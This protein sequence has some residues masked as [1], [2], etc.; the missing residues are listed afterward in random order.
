MD[1]ALPTTMGGGGKLGLQQGWSGTKTWVALESR[2]AVEWEL[3]QVLLDAV[4]L[5]LRLIWEEESLLWWV[6]QYPCTA[7]LGDPAEEVQEGSPWARHLWA[8]YYGWRIWE[9][10]ETREMAV[11]SALN[12][13]P[14]K[15]E[16]NHMKQS[17]KKKK[18]RKHVK[19]IH[20]PFVGM[21]SF[22]WKL[23]LMCRWIC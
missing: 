17:K 19:R 3:F 21:W 7:E 5:F 12:Q 10:G 13:L 1:K 4:L 23:G 14:F 22:G 11:W 15:A 8:H 18:I 20:V 9:G 6:D 2:S 16:W